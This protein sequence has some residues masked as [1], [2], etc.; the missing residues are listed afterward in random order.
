M[1]MVDYICCFMAD[2]SVRYAMVE[3]FLSDDGH[4]RDPGFFRRGL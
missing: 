4:L 3:L 1:Y 2:Q